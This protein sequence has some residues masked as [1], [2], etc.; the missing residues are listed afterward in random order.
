[1]TTLGGEVVQAA[2]VA[3]VLAVG[4]VVLAWLKRR[5]TDGFKTLKR[6]DDAIPTLL[7]VADEFKPNG[8]ETLRDK[9]DSIAE[10][11]VFQE[12][13]R[14]MLVDLAVDAPF[15][16]CDARGQCIYVN[17]EWTRVTGLTLEE[18]RGGG[19]VAGIHHDDR[20]SVTEE[21]DEAAIQHREFDLVYRMVDRDGNITKV[22]GRSRVLR[23]IGG[24][25]VGMVGYN[26]IL[27]EGS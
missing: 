7:R 6:I 10:K 26:R 3:I 2:A 14:R 23:G 24:T 17:R 1:M 4:G 18:A 15:Y 25:V 11:L 19:W 21:W 9:V 8:G 16:E 20:E 13:A 22:H 5:L 27:E 12:G